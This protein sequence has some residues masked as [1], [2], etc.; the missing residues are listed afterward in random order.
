MFASLAM[1]AGLALLLFSSDLPALKVPRQGVLELHRVTVINPGAGPGQVAGARRKN[2]TLRVKDGRIAAIEPESET[3]AASADPPV[4]TF[5]RSQAS[6]SQGFG[7]YVLPGLIDSHVHSPGL[8]IAGDRELWSTL[9]LLH[10]V[11]TVRNLGDGG[12]SLRHKPE[13][14]AGRQAGPRIL[15]CGH[16]LDGVQDGSSYLS[17]A[18]RTPAD[19]HTIVQE[20]KDAGADC[21]KVLPHF[22]PELFA[23]VREA[24]RAAGLPLIGHMVNAYGEK[25]LELSGI[26]DVQHLTGVP[27]VPSPGMDELEWRRF[28]QSFEVLPPARVEAMVALSR[29]L[30]L[31]HT[32]TLIGPAYEALGATGPGTERIPVPIPRPRHGLV[33]D[34]YESVWSAFDAHRSAAD[35]ELALRNLPRYLEIVR[36]L[37]QAG[38]RVQAGSDSFTFIAHVVPGLGLHEEL[39]MLERA[40]F[41]AEEALAA[42]TNVPGTAMAQSSSAKSLVG[43]GT[44]AVNAPAD[45][46]IFR[47]D[48]TVS[49]AALD[50][51]E[52]VIAAGRRYERAD[53]QR[54]LSVQLERSRRFPY[55][56]S[57]RILEWLICAFAGASS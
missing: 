4:A 46:L 45:L 14:A 44:I 8:P 37:H 24:A 17:R 28:R 6:G 48:P 22:S 3:D 53:L 42:A 20:L 55:S 25:G 2:V 50:T 16:L 36:A 9:Y 56:W 18:I 23:A 12:L 29:R 49:L 54:H 31:V 51:L 7:G 30:D 19:A 26:V 11:T 1:A 5:D 13:V 39:A 52:T 47:E 57:A 35:R 40:G 41:S 10:G 38:V 15:A 27:P 43:L 33:P 21:I 34:W 32:P